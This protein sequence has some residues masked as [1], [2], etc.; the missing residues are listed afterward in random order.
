[1]VTSEIINS[2]PIWGSHYQGIAFNKKKNKTE[3]NMNVFRKQQDLQ[4]FKKINERQTWDKGDGQESMETTLAVIHYI[5]DMKP[6]E[7][8]SCSH[9]R[10]PVEQ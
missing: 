1:M 8:T 2:T 10:S 4:L 9:A 6:E 7:A 3:K 5:G